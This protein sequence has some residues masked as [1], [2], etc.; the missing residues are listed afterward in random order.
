MTVCLFQEEN[1]VHYL[2]DFF[3]FDV[4]YDEL[5]EFKGTQKSRNIRPY[6]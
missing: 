4:L 2:L 5:L 6:P 1:N 3:F